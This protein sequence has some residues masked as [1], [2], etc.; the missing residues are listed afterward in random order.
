M[1]FSMVCMNVFLFNDLEFGLFRD[2]SKLQ[3]LL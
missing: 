3:V 2:W 1:S